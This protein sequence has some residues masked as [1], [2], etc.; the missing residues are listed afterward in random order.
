MQTDDCA[1]VRDYPNVIGRG[2]AEENDLV[3]K[4]LVDAV[5]TGA[6]VLDVGCNAGW[7]IEELEAKGCEVVGVEAATKAFAVCRQ[8]GL[9]VAF[10][11]A[12]HL[13]VSDEDFDVV[14][15]SNLLQQVADVEPVVRELI[16]VCSTGG[17]V[18]GVNAT[19]SGHWGHQAIG[20]NSYVRQVLDPE[21]FG[22][23]FAGQYTWRQISAENYLW[24]VV[25]DRLRLQS[26]G[27][28]M[29]VLNCLKY[30]KQAVRSLV[31]SGHPYEIIVIDNASTDGTGAWFREVDRPVHYLKQAKNIGV[32]KSWNLGIKTAFERGH[33]LVFVINNDLVFAEDTFAR[34]VRCRNRGHEF[35]TVNNVGDSPDCLRGYLRREITTRVPGF[36][37]FLMGPDVVE[38]VGWFDEEYEQ[39]YYE[40][41]D[42]DER[43]KKDGIVPVCCIDAIV[44]HYGS[45]TRIEGGVNHEPAFSRNKARFQ[46]KWGYLPQ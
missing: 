19:P 44:A 30:T 2:H 38:R 21:L 8:K 23:Y 40:D 22:F 11:Y 1:L 10:G 14:V 34:L 18:L 24:Q 6:R 42:F 9:P 5:P 36:F 26:V 15:A 20:Q 28:V 31:L 45:R 13:P 3:T 32:A 29:P 7:L 17:T 43:M 33:D 35:V 41:L 46:S 16:R 12:E 27:V 25:V 4:A 39:A 37:G